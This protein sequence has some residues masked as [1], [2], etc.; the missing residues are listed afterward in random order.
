MH[1]RLGLRVLG[2]I[3]LICQT[4]VPVKIKRAFTDDK[5]AVVTIDRNS[6]FR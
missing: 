3:R 2:I 5:K 1:G 6:V 4:S